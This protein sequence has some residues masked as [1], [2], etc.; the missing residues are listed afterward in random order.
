MTRNRS[1]AISITCFLCFDVGL[2]D[3]LRVLLIF[4][5][6]LFLFFTVFY[7]SGHSSP[8]TH[9]GL[10]FGLAFKER[11]VIGVTKWTPVFVALIWF[12]LFPFYT[13]GIGLHQT[14]LILGAVP[15]S[16]HGYRY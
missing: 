14:R 7:W 4:C 3:F 10:I 6:S 2:A 8:F 12:A 16:F 13:L 9:L 15:A 5:L 11:S 1:Y